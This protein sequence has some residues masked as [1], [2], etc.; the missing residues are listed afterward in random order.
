MARPAAPLIVRT[1]TIPSPG[2][3]RNLVFIR[4]STAG[5]SPAPRLIVQQNPPC[6][7]LPSTAVTPPLDSE[8]QP[9]VTNAPV[10]TLLRNAPISMRFDGQPQP[11]NAIPVAS[12]ISMNR[13]FPGPGS[14]AAAAAR[15][16]AAT[17]TTTG[18]SSQ[19]FNRKVVREMQVWLIC[20]DISRFSLTCF[21][22]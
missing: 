6:T 22:F 4:P 16:R 8:H 2:L 18:T 7:I 21:H 15:L 13:P 5:A 19:A 9:D 10:A 12:R 11:I 3:A 17:A 14:G 1:S 20:C